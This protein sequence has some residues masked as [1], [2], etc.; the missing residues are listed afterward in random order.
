M[1]KYEKGDKM[2]NRIEIKNNAKT[3]LKHFYLWGLL[4]VLIYS[5]LSGELSSMFGNF[6]DI[7][8]IFHEDSLEYQEDVFEFTQFA[9]GYYLS[10]AAIFAI[11]VSGV[12]LLVRAALGILYR[13]FIVNVVE[14]GLYSFFLKNRHKETNLNEMLMP[15][16]TNYKNVVKVTFLKNLYIWLWTLLLV[17]PGIIKYYEYYFVSYLLAEDPN[18]TIQEAIATSKKMTDGQKLDILIFDLSF[19]G[20]IILGSIL[21]GVGQILVLPYIHA[22]KSEL[23]ICLKERRLEKHM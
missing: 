21:G 12:F 16:Q 7:T 20:W 17:I 10:L 8:S 19:L 1:N 13:V 22:S 2:F 11:L 14:I 4:A 23:Y 3:A 6:Q 18:L 9:E 5:F 15:F